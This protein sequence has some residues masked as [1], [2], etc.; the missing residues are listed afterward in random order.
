[1][2][3]ARITMLC[4]KIFSSFH[5]LRIRA[6]VTGFNSDGH[7]TDIIKASV[8][9]LHRCSLSSSHTT[10]SPGEDSVNV[11]G[12]LP[13]RICITNFP[14]SSN[15]MVFFPRWDF[16]SLHSPTLCIPHLI[17]IASV[18][19]NDFCLTKWP[20]IHPPVGRPTTFAFPNSGCIKTHPAASSKAT[21][22]WLT[23]VEIPCLPPRRTMTPLRVS[24][25]IGLPAM[26]SACR[27]LIESGGALR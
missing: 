18:A 4:N 17:S 10:K 9:A 3:A 20:R 19:R 24:I 22:I 7:R 1:M 21:I 26:R 27:E 2:M 25:S 8:I 6:F 13:E 16:Q 11:F 15:V 12:R 5:F 23:G 14:E